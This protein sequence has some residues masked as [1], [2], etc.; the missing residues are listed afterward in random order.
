MLVARAQLD[1]I[2]DLVE[3]FERDDG[4]MR[5]ISD[6]RSQYIAIVALLR[7]V[8]HVFEKVD[9]TDAGRRHWSKERWR[10]WRQNPIFSDFIEPTRNALLK[11]S[12]GGLQ[13]HDDAFVAVAAVADPSMPSGASL[14]ASFDR[15]EFR[16]AE[17]RPILPQLR[18]ALD[19]W[20]QCLQEAEAQFGDAD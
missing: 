9:C 13:R 6:Y 7:S 20:D 3:R 2:R 15:S 1:F 11:E 12:Q 17:G 18:T 14:I 8:G 16:D 4:P 10:T 5:S 19:F